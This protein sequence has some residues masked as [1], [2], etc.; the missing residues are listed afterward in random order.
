MDKQ[1]TIEVTFPIFDT[2][3]GPGTYV[4]N[5]IIDDPEDK[6]E[7]PAVVTEESFDYLGHGTANDIHS[8]S[9]V[10]YPFK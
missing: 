2:V 6:E 9:S 4:G 5:M 3:P 1:K 8:S 7:I 10:P